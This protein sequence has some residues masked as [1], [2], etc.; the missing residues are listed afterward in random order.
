MA[1]KSLGEILNPKQSPVLYILAFFLSVPLLVYGVMQATFTQGGAATGGTTPS[2]EFTNLS[3]GQSVIEDDSITVNLAYDSGGC[4]SILNVNDGLRSIYSA[5][6]IDSGTL[7]FNYEFNVPGETTL[8]S[9]L[10]PASGESG[11]CA[12]KI[13]DTVVLNVVP[14]TL[15]VHW[16][17]HP[18]DDEDVT[19]DQFTLYW[20]ATGFSSLS[21][22]EYSIDATAIAPGSISR[23]IKSG[24]L[25]DAGLC[26]GPTA[27]VSCNYNWRWED[28]I[29][30]GT[31]NITISITDT[32]P[33]TTET[34]SDVA[35]RVKLRAPINIGPS[36]TLSADVTTVDS[37]DSVAFTANATDPDDSL[38]YGTVTFGD[39]A[40]ASISPNG[41]TVSHI[42]TNPNSTS[43]TRTA[44]ATFSDGQASCACS[45]AITVLG[46]T[47]PPAPNHAPVFE[48]EPETKAVVGETYSYT[49]SAKDPD[50]GDT[51][52]YGWSKKPSWLSWNASQHKLSGTPSSADANKTFRVSVSA[53]DGEATTTQSFV[54]TVVGDVAGAS[55]EPPVVTIFYPTQGAQ[56]YCGQSFIKW[57]ATDAD[58]T[59]ASIKLEYSTDQ[60]NWSTI[61]EEVDGSEVRYDWDV[62]NLTYGTYYVSVTAVDDTGVPGVGQSEAFA[63]VDAAS[64]QAGPDIV[65]W[66]PESSSI[67]N[68]SQ[69]VISA[70]F[71]ATTSAIDE[72]TA[73]IMV[74]DENVTGSSVVSVNGF[75]YTP[76]NAISEGE[77]TVTVTISDVDGR[78]SELTWTFTIA[79]T[80]GLSWPAVTAIIC[81]ILA[82]LALLIA[83]IWKRRKDGKDKVQK[84]EV[85]KKSIKVDEGPK[86]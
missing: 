32:D 13:S 21:T 17:A 8:Y 42:Y 71:V 53:T 15:G 38:G 3:T 22:T 79:L 25:S 77:H 56:L 5:A 62:C 43:I 27:G 48:S 16:G 66:K 11:L 78:T 1:S 26:N 23:T 39:G 84:K 75:S 47:N 24:H 28:D 83:W 76:Q 33:V 52:S 40:S 35:S 50:S 10:I 54:I 63:I 31:Y 65:N 70:D 49:L 69:P 12:Q 14:D 30:A 4:V 86:K 85:S 61:A 20:T 46:V 58:G 36:C 72:T 55:T 44:Q 82:L 80:G 37:G 60:E 81:A 59:V 45:R 57:E 73:I 67:V 18:Y 2:L 6:T 41:V 68:E 19:T 64:I 29:S 9:S 74:D 34:A 51:V 7:S